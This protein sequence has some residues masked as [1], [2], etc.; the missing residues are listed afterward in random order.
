MHQQETESLDL[1]YETTKLKN[2]FACHQSTSLRTLSNLLYVL[3]KSE[4]K[5][6]S[7]IV[8]TKVYGRPSLRATG[9]WPSNMGNL[10]NAAA[11]LLDGP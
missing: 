1:L 3:S 6:A 11:A 9:Q 4:R 10:L 8:E 7:N 2:E 5:K